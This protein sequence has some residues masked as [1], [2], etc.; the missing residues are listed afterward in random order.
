[1]GLLTTLVGTYPFIFPRVPSSFFAAVD[2]L[3]SEYP[4]YDVFG[5]WPGTLARTELPIFFSR[6]IAV[7]RV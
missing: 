4:E 2:D 6:S 3:E 5:S 7:I 1:M